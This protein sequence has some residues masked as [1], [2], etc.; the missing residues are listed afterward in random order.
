MTWFC[1]SVLSPSAAELESSQRGGKNKSHWSLWT[2]HRLCSGL[3]EQH[4]V[5]AVR[6]HCFDRLPVALCFG[7]THWDEDSPAAQGWPA[8]QQ[9]VGLLRP[10]PLHQTRSPRWCFRTPV[11]P[12]WQPVLGAGSLES[13]WRAL[14][15]GWGSALWGPVWSGKHKS[16]ISGLQ[17]TGAKFK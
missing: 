3:W 5:N 12:R 7:W 4:K 15:S 6:T 10:P 17:S 1:A 14:R 13:L 8:P 11:Q 16:N 2:Q 9:Q